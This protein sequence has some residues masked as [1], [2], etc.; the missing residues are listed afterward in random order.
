MRHRLPGRGVRAAAVAAAL[1][2]LVAGCAQGGD[3]ASGPTPQA[4]TLGEASQGAT[5]GEAAAGA[6]AQ[7]SLTSMGRAA[8]SAVPGAGGPRSPA[9]P[10]GEA[11]VVP[12]PAR[13][14]APPAPAQEQ[15]PRT[16]PGRALLTVDD[17]R[18]T[19]GGH[20]RHR[21]GGA[22]EC[23]VPEGA[24]AER[25]TS[26]GTPAGTVVQTVASYGDLRRADAAVLD[27]R[28]AAERCGWTDVRDPRIGSAAV[29]AVDDQG[30]SMTA[31]SVDGAV[32]VLLGSGRVVAGSR[33]Q[34]LVERALGS[35][36]LAAVGGCR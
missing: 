16:V 35:S 19:Y 14:A 2:L 31:V 17:L 5:P 1:G 8:R 13:A 23:V 33:W 6:A 18:R 10:D 15:A 26:Y 12:D 28:Y 30:R 25:T 27:L 7:Q 4:R 36:C 21:A 22:D 24:L 34:E 29:T 9:H 11:S 32:V 20:W 3:V